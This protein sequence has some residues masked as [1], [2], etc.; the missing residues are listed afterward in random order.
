[1]ILF[2]L[3]LNL[4]RRRSAYFYDLPDSGI[5]YDDSPW[6]NCYL[7]I[8]KGVNHFL[9]SSAAAVCRLVLRYSDGVCSH[10]KGK[11]QNALSGILVAIP[12]YHADADG[13]CQS[14]AFGGSGDIT[15]PFGKSMTS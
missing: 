3:F 10:T 1:M 9:L 15:A 13:P 4:G 8:T 6:A 11:F 5:S 14:G 7:A 12:L 2:P